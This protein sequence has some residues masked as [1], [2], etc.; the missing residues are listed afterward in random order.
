MIILNQKK[1]SENEITDQA[2]YEKRR[3]FMKTAAGIGIAAV[4]GLPIAQ[5]SAK[6]VVSPYSTDEELTEYKDIT[7]YCNFYE[8]GTGIGS[9]Q[10]CA[11]IS[12]FAVGCVG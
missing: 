10:K 8:F 9:Y 12:Y 3:D 1:I 11:Y 2:V 5:L 7:S 6:A 4:S